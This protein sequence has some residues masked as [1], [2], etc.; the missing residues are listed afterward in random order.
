MFCKII[1]SVRDLYF[2]RPK[3]GRLDF[4]CGGSHDLSVTVRMATIEEDKRDD[5]ASL[6]EA[7]CKRAPKPHIL[8]MFESLSKNQ[9]PE[10]S[11]LKDRPDYIDA[12][13]SI[14]DNHI[15]HME[16]M[17]VSFQSYAADIRQELDY[18]AKN[19]VLALRWASGL[20]GPHNPFGH[21]GFK[22]SF[23]K[24]DWHAFPHNY[25]LHMVGS[26]ALRG[27]SNTQKFVLDLIAKGGCEP[28]GHELYREAWSQKLG[29]PRSSLIL[30]IVSAETAVK[31]CIAL[32]QPQT[33]WLIE[34]LPSPDLI[35]LIRDY[36]PKLPAKNLINGKVLPP[37]PDL[38]DLIKKGVQMR[39]IIAHGGVLDLKYETLEAI[40]KAV[41]QLL[42]MQDY[43]SGNDWALKHV[44]EETKTKLGLPKH[45]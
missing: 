36:L 26:G 12:S 1:Y 13:G 17:P 14:K 19:T 3:D 44:D 15:V 9:M 18:Y 29:N 34:N 5:N 23:D 38:M 42:W 20:K 10:G 45:N 31:N 25:K 2:A 35:R 32:L 4:Y 41:N 16:L 37:P 33:Q 8:K 11:N 6:S 28:L 24:I 40:L 43:Y 7:V 22:W 39:N 27:D 21:V 30:G